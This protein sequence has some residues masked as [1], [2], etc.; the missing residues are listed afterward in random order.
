MFIKKF[1]KAL[2]LKDHFGA[3]FT[4]SLRKYPKS[5][6]QQKRKW[7]Y[8]RAGERLKSSILVNPC[9]LVVSV[10]SDVHVSELILP[11]MIIPSSLV[12]APLHQKT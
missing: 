4:V 10:S 9:S 2:S 7:L 8:L 5:T 1:Y 11:Y 6:K 12:L 3:Q